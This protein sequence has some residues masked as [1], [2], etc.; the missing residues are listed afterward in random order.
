[1]GRDR[2]EEDEVEERGGAEEE[3]EEHTEK[4]EEEHLEEKE[5]RDLW[6]E[7]MGVATSFLEEEGAGERFEAA[8]V[9]VSISIEE[10]GSSAEGAA[11]SSPRGQR[12]EEEEG[13][14][15][16]EEE[17]ESLATWMPTEYF[18][19]RRGGEGE[20]EVGEGLFPVSTF[21]KAS[22]GETSELK[23]EAAHSNTCAVC[24]SAYTSVPPKL[25]QL[26]RKRTYV[27]ASHRKSVK[28]FA[29][30]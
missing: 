29:D 22:D 10:D 7:A 2:G 25:L 24:T 3:E 19:L 16:E 30:R 11:D 28:L 8:P 5:R 18:T 13:E 27:L 6:E 1:M 17:E 15:A 23:R 21:P 14:G 12:V 4:E 20:G 9:E 26:V